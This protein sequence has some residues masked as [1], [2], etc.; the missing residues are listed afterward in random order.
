MRPKGG[1]Y[2]GIS[3]EV[4]RS[5]GEAEE[6][7]GDI[8]TEL[9]YTFQSFDGKAELEAELERARSETTDQPPSTWMELDGGKPGHK[10]TILRLFMDPSL[11]VD[12][13]K[14]HDRLLRVR[15]FSIG[16]DSWDRSKPSNVLSGHTSPSSSSTF[17]LGSLYATLVCIDQ[18]RVC[19]AV[20]QCTSLKSASQCID[21][22]PADEIA[23]P[24]SKYDVSGQILSLVPV[25]LRVDSLQGVSTSE[26]SWIW[27]SNYVA[28]NTAKSRTTQP[29]SITRL[30][31]L[32]IPVN[33][34]LVY[35]LP[36]TKYMSTLTDTLHLA[37]GLMPN[38]MEKTWVIMETDL[39]DIESLLHQRARDN[40][41]ALSKIPLFGSVRDGL[42]PYR[43]VISTLYIFYEFLVIYLY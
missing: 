22:A 43:A 37:P 29:T 19:V 2:P 1:K 16:G 36:P 31:H 38:T 26:S 20:L 33:G 28:L 35:P 7:Q 11:D 14:S 6:R 3:A 17:G 24:D 8:E 15:Y 34:R 41:D 30:Y 42:F 9:D 27:N 4:D 12:Y 13:N 32:S 23:L 10:K 5:L 25:S 40:E 21:H 18:K 39:R